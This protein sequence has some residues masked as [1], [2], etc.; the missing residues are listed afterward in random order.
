MIIM[1]EFLVISTRMFDRFN[2]KY[3]ICTFLVRNLSDFQFM[4]SDFFLASYLE[5]VSA[6]PLID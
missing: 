3:L 4:L 5:A 6:D 1:I 2:Y